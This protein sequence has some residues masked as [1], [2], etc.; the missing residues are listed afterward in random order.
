MMGTASASV[1]V[2]SI[3][4]PLCRECAAMGVLLAACFDRHM[5]VLIAQPTSAAVLCVHTARTASV[6]ALLTVVTELLHTREFV[7]VQPICTSN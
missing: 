1:C 3:C 6:V 7:R 2:L 4:N 5:C